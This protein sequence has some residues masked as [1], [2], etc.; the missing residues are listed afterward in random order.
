MTVQQEP[1]VIESKITGRMFARFAMYDIFVRRKGWRSPL[2]FLLMMS[3]FATLCFTVLGDRE[4]SS[5]LGLVLL[6]VGIV[7]P[8]IWVLMYIVSV[9][10]QI[11]K[12]KLRSS[13]TQYTL[14]LSEEKIHVIKGKEAA[15][16]LWENASMLVDDGECAYLYVDKAK[17]FILPKNERWPN[18]LLLAE[19]KLEPSGIKG[20]K[21][22]S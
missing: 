3:T 13:R 17:A 7:L 12:L 6:S 8:V 14:E 5:L 22:K 4:Q 10:S 19:Q 18:I 20:R 11:K 1:I 21:N 15:D 16:F 2:A 9:R